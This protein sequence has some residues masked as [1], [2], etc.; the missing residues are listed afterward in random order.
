MV[1][2]KLVLKRGQMHS[3]TAESRKREKEK[4]DC[5]HQVQHK[6]SPLRNQKSVTR[7]VQACHLVSVSRTVAPPF[8]KDVVHRVPRVSNPIVLSS[9]RCTLLPVALCLPLVFLSLFSSVTLHTKFSFWKRS[10]CGHTHDMLKEP[11][12]VSETLRRKKTYVS[13][14]H[15]SNLLAS[16][17]IVFSPPHSEARIFFQRRPGITLFR[18]YLFHDKVDAHMWNFVDSDEAIS[19]HIFAMFPNSSCTRTSFECHV[20][21]RCLLQKLVR[22]HPFLLETPGD[23]RVISIV[24]LFIRCC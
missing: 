5:G 11:D 22:S 12:S 16:F 13:T 6:Y 15:S 23:F 19:A 18:L 3:S 2:E 17:D 10:H 4:S 9:T 8:G 24:R 21:P 1:G 14:A 20:P 7:Q